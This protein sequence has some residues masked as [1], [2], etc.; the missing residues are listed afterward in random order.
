[1]EGTAWQEWRKLSNPGF[2][3]SH[4][5]KLVPMIVQEASI[6]MSLLAEHEAKGDVSH[7]KELT[8]NLTMDIIGQIVVYVGYVS[9]KY[10]PD[11]IAGT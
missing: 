1:M 11:H 5:I 8:D 10:P 3:A 7:V 2:S 6:F 4:L 9:H